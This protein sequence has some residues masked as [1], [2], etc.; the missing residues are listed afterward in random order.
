MT[1]IR[2]NFDPKTNGFQFTNRF[3]GGAVV[4]ELARQDRLS[5][6]TGLKV[7][8]A[9][10]NLT[11]LASGA[12]FWGTFGLCGG[13]SSGALA[14]FKHGEPVPVTRSIPEPD[15]ELF[16]ELVRRQAETLQGRKVL[17]RCLAWQLSPDR[18]STWMF[19]TKGIAWL[20]TE[21]EWPRLRAA[22][23][24]GS[25]TLLCLL[26]VRGVGSPAD[27]HQVVAVGADIAADG[28]VLV[29]M[30]DPNHPRAAPT[31]TLDTR[32]RTVGPRQSTGEPVRGFFV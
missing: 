9:V 6:L 16:R 11:D 18:A 7:P 10:R 24:G 32:N 30:Y 21:R 26:R 12:G 4:A 15:S 20:T 28:K 3:P 22:L 2:T 31:F 8:R 17:E 25:P 13:M 14:R 27:N 29:H 19:W 1:E 5:E 23:Q